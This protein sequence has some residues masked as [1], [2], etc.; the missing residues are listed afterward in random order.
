MPLCVRIGKIDLSNVQ[1]KKDAMEALEWAAQH[2][3][4]GRTNSLHGESNRKE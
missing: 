2:P 3:S 4:R 1:R